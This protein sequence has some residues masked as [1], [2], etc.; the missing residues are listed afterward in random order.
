MTANVNI[1]QQHVPHIASFLENIYIDEESNDA[2]L[3]SGC[4]LIGY[5]RA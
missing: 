3:A 2:V 4:G 5:V 1:M